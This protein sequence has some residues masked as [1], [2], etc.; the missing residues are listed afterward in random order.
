MRKLLN[1]L[2]LFLSNTSKRWSNWNLSRKLKKEQKIIKSRNAVIS[3]TQ[4]S[5]HIIIHEGQI[6][7][8]II[9]EDIVE[10]VNS[11]GFDV[12]DSELLAKLLMEVKKHG[13]II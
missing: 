3:V 4:Q 5:N 6:Y 11:K 1:K 8:L 10:C 2:S 7:R 12:D 13:T 9:Q